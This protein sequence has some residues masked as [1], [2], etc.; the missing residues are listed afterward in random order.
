MS[1]FGRNYRI[2]TF[3]ESHCKAVGVIVDGTPSKMDFDIEYIQ[4]QLNRRRPG[5]SD[6]TTPRDEKDK[7][8]IMS[9]IEN[10]KT[11]GTPICAM[12]YNNNI[13]KQDYGFLDLDNYI[14]RP[15]HADYSYIM[16]YGTHASSGGGRS[17]ARETIGRVIAGTIAELYLSK[18]YNIEIVAFVSRIGNL[19]INI[20]EDLLN[21]ITREDVDKTV[22]RCPNIEISNK[23]KDFIKKL[24]NEGDSIGGIVTCVCRN[25]PAGIGE[26]CF[27]KL[28]ALLAHAMMSIPATKGFEIGS[29]FSCCGM[30]GSEHNDEFINSNGRIR[31]K[32]NFSG[33][34]QGGI[35]NGENIYFNIA[36]K[37]ASSISK[38]QN[39]VDL[40]GNYKKLEVNGRHDP[41]FVYRAVPIVE[42]MSA[43]VLMDYL[44]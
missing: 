25:V 42:A 9:G 20:N 10:G 11:L 19:K 4:K 40:K 38:P 22:V 15:S 23:M 32:T 12:V 3:G 34:I 8:M 24:Q 18:K 26:P 41:C 17:S 2:S 21:S 1:I 33:G 43:C 27:D 13:R 35:S 6:I 29:G 5:Q 31:T 36:F 37:P 14:P 16:K 28:E 30:K 39:T 44:L 7:I